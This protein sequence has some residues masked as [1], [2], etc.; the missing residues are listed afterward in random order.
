MAADRLIGNSGTAGAIPGDT[1]MDDI[2]GEITGLWNGSIIKVTSPAGTNIYTGTITPALTAGLVDGMRFELV[3]PNT[4]TSGTCSFNGNPIV[5]RDGSALNPG[6]LRATDD[7]LLSWD[8]GLTKYRVLS[9]LPPLAFVDRPSFRNIALDNGGFEVWQRGAG[10]SA[11]IAIAASTTSGAYAPD[12]WY[13][14]TNATQAS[15]VSAQAGLANRS[16]LAARVQ[17]N[18]GQTGVGTM[19]FAYPLT[20]EECVRMRGGQICLQFLAK[21]GANWSPTSGT[22]SYDVYFGAGAEGK[23]GAGFTSESHPITGTVN[24]T[25]GGAL[26]TVTAGPSSALGTTI[27]QGEIRFSWTPAA[28]AAGAADYVDLDNVQLE[29]ATAPTEFE[30]APIEVLLALCQRHY[31]KTFP[32]ATAPVTNGGFAGA[33]SALN[34]GDGAGNANFPGMW[35]FPVP[36]RSSPT[37]AAFNPAAA[38]TTWRVTTATGAFSNSVSNAGFNTLAATASENGCIVNLAVPSSDGT[39]GN[40][41]ANYIGYIHATADASL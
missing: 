38:A 34:Q 36:M 33:L 4:S 41:P 37:L 10:D 17:R 12:R 27:T 19:I 23:R 21:A 40:S 13:L 22:L 8:S 2:A 31:A 5:R 35:R 9:Y 30:Y 18:S 28:G 11:S 29:V 1:E 7:L 20:K 24:V 14:I 3:I 39:I 26:Q 6:D 32:Y 25:A 16:K 15:V